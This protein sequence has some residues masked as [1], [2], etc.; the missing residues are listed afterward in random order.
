VIYIDQEMTLDDLEERADD[1]G[2]DTDIDDLS[3]LHYYQLQSFAPFDTREGSEQ[4][5]AL[6]EKH[7]AGLVIIDTTARVV[8]GS[9]NDADTYL[10]LYRETLQHLKAA[11]VT[12]LRLDHAG[13]EATKGQRGSSA[14]NDD[15][16]VV[17]RLEV[18][19]HGVT[20]T[21]ERQRIP[22]VPQKVEMKRDGARHSMRN[23]WAVSQAVTDCIGDLDKVG[24]PLDIGTRASKRL[25][26]QHGFKGRANETRIEAINHR[27][28]QAATRPEPPPSV[29]PNG[30]EHPPTTEPTEEEEHQQEHPT[31]ERQKPGDDGASAFLT[32]ER[33]TQGTPGGARSSLPAPPLGG[34]EETRDINDAEKN[35]ADSGLVPPDDEEEQ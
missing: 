5:L 33:N 1:L 13:K 20:L 19:K 14:K 8:E 31:P 22:W 4:L 10:N 32:E 35:L 25:L 34:A 15:V 21:A 23:P 16:D 9:E 28:R 3:N 18:D 27:K 29:P 26:V 7:Q 30:E 2:Y 12:V 6:R 24:A 11:G 17:W